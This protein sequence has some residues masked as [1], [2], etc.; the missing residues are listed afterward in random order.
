MSFDDEYPRRRLT[1]GML[2]EYEGCES[3]ATDI[4]CGR[5][6]H[7]SDRPGHPEPGVYC[8]PHTVDVTG[9]NSPE[10]VDYCPNCGC[11]FGVN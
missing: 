1:E 5:S 9:E 10:Y 2:C 3:P 4:A 11:G 8:K 6:D 7:H